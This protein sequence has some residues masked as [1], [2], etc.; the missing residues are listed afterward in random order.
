MKRTSLPSLNHLMSRYT[1]PIASVEPST[2]TL[3]VAN[4]ASTLRP[5]TAA[6]AAAAP[7]ATITEVASCAGAIE[8]PYEPNR[9]TMATSSAVP[10]STPPTACCN[11]DASGPE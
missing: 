6:D 9:V 5:A 7:S 2:S 3:T 8:P 4:C 11:C 10:I 1:S